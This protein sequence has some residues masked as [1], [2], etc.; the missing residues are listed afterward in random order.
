MG[1]SLLLKIIMPL[2]G[3]TDGYD[4]TF[5]SSPLVGASL[6]IGGSD[7]GRPHG[8]TRKDK[9]PRRTAS[10]TSVNSCSCQQAGRNFCF[11]SDRSKHSRG[12]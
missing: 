9:R 7:R 2:Q 8:V 10:L 5:S 4:T 11:P 3:H 12:C 6:S 1:F